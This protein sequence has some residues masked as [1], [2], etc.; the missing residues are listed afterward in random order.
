MNGAHQKGLHEG[1][2]QG[3]QKGRQ[4]IVLRMAEH[5]MTGKDIASV[6]RLSEQEVNDILKEPH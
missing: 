5:G 1:L 3:F 6:T 4:E 2:Q